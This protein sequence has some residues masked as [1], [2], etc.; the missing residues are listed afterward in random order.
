MRTASFLLFA[1]LVVIGCAG[2][3]SVLGVP[4]VVSDT[5]FD[6]PPEI[7]NPDEV[8]DAMRDQYPPLLRDARIGGSVVLLASV[9]EMGRV[10][11]SSLAESSGH[12]ALDQLAL[13]LASILRFTPAQHGGR[14]VRVMVKI[15]MELVPGPPGR[16][17]KRIR[18]LN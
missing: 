10:Q 4:T 8:M 3:G 6:L 2:G 16:A 18:Y 13:E 11:N 5:A 12:Q 1:L 17:T 14:A 7:T 9:G 15:P